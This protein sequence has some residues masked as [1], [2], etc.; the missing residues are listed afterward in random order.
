[1]GVGGWGEAAA[2]VPEGGRHVTPGVTSDRATERWPSCRRWETRAS[3][4]CPVTCGRGWVPLAIR[5]VR[6]DQGHPVPLP[7]SEC[8]RVPRPSPVQDCSPK[9]CPARWAP[10]QGDGWSSAPPCKLLSALPCRTPH[11]CLGRLWRA[12]GTRD[13]VSTRGRWLVNPCSSPSV[14]RHARGPF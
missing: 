14:A 4:P 12:S 1:M 7:P 9:P 10:S 11:W 6:L 3:A 5:C 8:W 2:W 13:A